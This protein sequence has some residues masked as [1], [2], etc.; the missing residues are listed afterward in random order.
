MRSCTI[1]NCD[2]CGRNVVL[3]RNYS[4]PP[5]ERFRCSLCGEVENL[6]EIQGESLF[7]N[8]R[9][10]THRPERPEFSFLP[11][12]YDE[13]DDICHSIRQSLLNSN[14]SVE[15]ITENYWGNGLIVTWRQKDANVRNNTFIGLSE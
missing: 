3:T 12:R 1:F 15:S 14:I 8:Q 10:V 7:G 6:M 9:T 4:F 2:S 13:G 11:E 5:L